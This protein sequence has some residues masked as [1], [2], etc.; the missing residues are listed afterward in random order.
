MTHFVRALLL[1]SL[2][3]AAAG[4]NRA[5]VASTRPTTAPSARD[6]I[7]YLASDELE[8]RGVGTKGIDQAA[9]YIA[10]QFRRDGLKPLPTFDGYFQRFEMNTG[11]FVD[12]GTRLTV[13]GDSLV[14]DKSFKPLGFSGSGA[15]DGPVVFA[16]YGIS[17]AKYDYDDYSGLDVTGKVVL[18]L[19]FEPHNEAGKSRFVKGAY[20]EEATFKR[21]AEVAAE[22]GAV[23]LLVVN[24]PTHHGK[25][26]FVPFASLFTESR[27][28]IP[29]VQ[30][31]VDA[32]N[33]LLKK[34]RVADDLA[35]LQAKIDGSGKPASV[36]LKDVTA[37]GDIR[38]LH[39]RSGVMNVAGV[40]PGRGKLKDEYVVVGA[41]Y[42]HVGKSR[43]FSR[44]GKDGEIH[45][46]ADDNASGVSTMLSLAHT[47]AQP[48]N[49]Q[50]RDRRSII[51]IAFTGE[52]W[53]LLGSQ[54]FVNHPPAPL[55]RM[56]AMLNLDMVGRVRNEMLFVSGTGTA[57][58]LETIVHDADAASPLKVKET[59]SGFGPSDHTSFV[60]KKIPSLF[61][62]SGTHADYHTPRDDADKINYDGVAEVIGFGRRVV[63]GL[64][65]GPRL[66]YVAVAGGSPHAGVAMGTGGGGV[67]RVT[68]GVV[69]DYTSL[70]GTEGVRITGTSP[71][72][73]AEAAGLKDGDVITA[74][75]EKKIADLHDLSAALAAGKAGDTIKLK[76]RRDGQDL[77][78]S[79]TLAERKE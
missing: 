52:E 5:A 1:A 58:G 33:T 36:E 19:R 2:W 40:V 14:L 79:A 25:D 15:F 28:A 64:A 76:L 46:G 60:L 69:P 22:R 42:D 9:H 66:E 65:T 27:S 16:G 39:K 45:N 44:G 56:V 11:A 47:F 10:D 62:F 75:G 18:A 54:H 78:L 4:C 77:E 74:F 3:V 70:E 29:I 51:F 35:G 7:Y 50:A 55:A 26:G 63:D 6:A 24:P 37:V 34:G 41:H 21:K 59:L 73:P 8:G 20:S 61:F 43:M 38:I 12:K 71:G 49:G 72:S 17:S 31:G 30:I 57:K 53:G 68:L 48:R 67:G 13:G 23:A 32:A